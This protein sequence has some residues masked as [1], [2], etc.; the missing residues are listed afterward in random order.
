[1]PLPYTDQASCQIGVYT[2]VFYNVAWR[3]FCE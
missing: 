2:Y 1:M 3:T